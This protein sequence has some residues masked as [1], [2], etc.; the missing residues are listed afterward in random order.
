[1][2]F[3]VTINVGIASVKFLLRDFSVSAQGMKRS[4]SRHRHSFTTKGVSIAVN[5]GSLRS[6]QCS[7]TTVKDICN[8][9]QKRRKCEI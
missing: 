4:V 9:Y 7:T 1:M 3:F 2:S 6:L 5:N 8:Q